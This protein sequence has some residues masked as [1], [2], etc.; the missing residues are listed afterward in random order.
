M[1]PRMRFGGLRTRLILPVVLAAVPA[2]WLVVQTSSAWRHHE[3]ADALSAG[4]QL[5]RHAAADHART[6]RHAHRSLATIASAS[7]TPDTPALRRMLNAAV[8]DDGVFDNLGVVDSGGQVLDSYRELDQGSRQRLQALVTRAE[9]GAATASE[10]VVDDG[11]AEVTIM[12][13]EPAPASAAGRTRRFAFGVVK[14]AW[15]D[16]PLERG[17]VPPGTA[18]G[19][20]DREA[21]VLTRHPKPS[22]GVIVLEPPSA[23]VQAAL[24]AAGEGTVEPADAQSHVYAYAPLRGTSPAEHLYMT[25]AI[26][27]AAATAGADHILRLT[28]GA[29]LLACAF[30]GGIAYVSSGRLARE[31]EALV[32][33]TTRLAGG[34]MTARTGGV[35]GTPELARLANA[36]D[37]LGGV[38]AEREQAI[39]RRHDELTQHER[40]IRAAIESG[41]D[42]VV[43]L[44]VDGTIRY[45]S[46]SAVQNY[47]YRVDEVIGRQAFS[48][49]HQD[50][51]KALR[52]QFAEV[53][54]TP[55]ATF[56]ATIRARAKPGPWRWIESDVS[57]MLAEPSVRA[58]VAKFRDVTESREADEQRRQLH[59][60]LESRV[61]ERTAALVA[62]N[63]TLVKLSSA[64]EQTADSVFI[65]NATG[66]IE[67]VNPAFEAM[68]GFSREEALGATPRLISSGLQD[69]RF[70]ETLWTTI[71][72]GGV[73]RSI[74]TNKTKDGRLFSEDQSITPIRD[75]NGEITH[76]VSTGRDITERKRTEQALRRLNAALENES[77]RIAS[78]L[79]DEAGQF[80]SSAHITLA[81][82]ARDLIPEQRERIQQVRHHLDLA[83]EQLR[84]VS[85]ELHPHMLDDLG[86]SEAVRFLGA[87][88]GRRNG[89]F[90]DVDVSLAAP[91]PRTVQSVF[92]RLVQEGLSNVAKHARATRASIALGQTEATF[93]CSIR[94][95]GVGFETTPDALALRSD[96]SLGLTLMRDRIEAVGGTLTIVSAPHRGTELRATVPMEH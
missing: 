3:V 79:H 76:F 19:V 35:A 74:V 50:D 39:L 59:E 96:F 93:S 47:G 34:E 8:Q 5:T 61:Q 58:I 30:A 67:Y 66:V 9:R 75:A 25:V 85:H 21:R 83:E 37:T 80:L 43:L 16:D 94:D 81:D 92:Y 40:R 41:L 27:R 2:T 56:R 53:G 36:L 44:D 10:Y 6:L 46:P 26:P 69:K 45:V 49:V 90:V 38:L 11:S 29:L 48:F 55:A 89:I 18:I 88:C 91:C 64:L 77:A 82:I 22:D 86:L 12:L 20:L 15:L 87:S 70:Y 23:V 14:L 78:V 71:L 57:N 52:A 72:S 63:Q 28:A 62:A 73:F 33:T 32:A 17:N 1:R 4:I 7:E 31:V 42:H 68:T 51:R 13:A 84:R 60:T 65:T 24:T 95:D 54:R